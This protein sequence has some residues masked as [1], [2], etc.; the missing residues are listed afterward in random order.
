MV[1]IELAERGWLPEVAVRLGIRRVIEGRL[2]QES[3]RFR[4]REGALRGWIEELRQSEVAPVPARANDQ[5]YEVPVRFFEAALGPNL[6]YSA[7]L[8]APGT[9]EL[10]EAEAAM[11]RLTCER[12]DLQDGQRILELGCGWGSLTLWMAA[13]FPH[14]RVTAVSNARSQREFILARARDRGLTNVEVVTADM[15]AFRPVGIFDRVVSVEMFE[16]MRNWPELVARIHG[17]LAPFGALFVH[18][19]AHRSFAYPFVDA[20]GD[21]WMARHFFTGGMMPSDDLLPRVRGPF[22]LEGHWVVPGSHYA[23]TAEAWHARLR[24]NRAAAQAAL[25][26]ALSPAE[27]ARQVRRWRIFFL[28][29]A[30]LFGFASGA[31]WFV[32]HYRLRAGGD[33]ASRARAAATP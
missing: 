29:C 1:G 8:W 14:A 23:R 26:A 28:S 20:S 17:W 27:A 31:E 5:H 2:R 4:D 6:K 22:R 19:F 15:N 24:A 18:V 25:E 21:D 13:H 12:A 10:A 33:R 30:E 9:T 32:S 16:H 11:L 7:A 3:A